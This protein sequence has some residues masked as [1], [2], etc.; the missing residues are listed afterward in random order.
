M[1]EYP[2][3]CGFRLQNGEWV[4]GRRHVNP[5]GSTGGV[6]P[7]NMTIPARVWIDPAAFVFPG[8]QLSQGEIVKKSVFER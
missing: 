6:V 4:R 2:H 8:V 1:Q 7:L 5:D 3:D